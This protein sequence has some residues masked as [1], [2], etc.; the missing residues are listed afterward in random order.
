LIDAFG[1]VIRLIAF[2]INLNEIYSIFVFVIGVYDT[3]AAI[4]SIPLQAFAREFPG[5]EDW[6]VCFV[7]IG[8]LLQAIIVNPQ[9]MKQF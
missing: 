2:K 7:Q 4:G 5:L 1:V 3:D 9:F 6:W 8:D